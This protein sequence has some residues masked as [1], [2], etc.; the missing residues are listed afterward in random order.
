MEDEAIV[1]EIDCREAVYESHY[2]RYVSKS[3]LF[4]YPY[5]EV[6]SKMEGTSSYQVPHKGAMLHFD[7]VNS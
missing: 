1:A 6:E 4:E 7:F 2:L 3:D 5:S